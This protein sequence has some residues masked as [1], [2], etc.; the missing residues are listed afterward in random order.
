MSKYLSKDRK[1]F[2]KF[3]GFGHF[4]EEIGER[5]KIL[6]RSGFGPRYL[7]NETGFGKYEVLNGELLRQRDISAHV[8]DTMARYC[9]MR[10]REMGA[11]SHEDSRLP[12][13]LAWNWKCEFGEELPTQ[14]LEV[15]RLVTADARMQPHEWIACEGRLLKL[16]ANSHGDDHFFPGPCDIAWDVA[17]AIV[18]WDMDRQAMEYFIDSYIRESGDRVRS[19]L[20]AYLLAYSTFR[21]GWSKMAAHASAGEFDQQLLERDYLRYREACSTLRRTAAAA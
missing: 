9:A 13:M 8:L 14:A 3:E 11:T 17:G 5:A 2:Y 12:E 6:Q 18:E 16:D 21:M 20:C 4:G 7:G 15:E 19:R 10:G 1:H